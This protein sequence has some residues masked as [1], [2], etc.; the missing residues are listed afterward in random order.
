MLGSEVFDLKWNKKNGTEQRMLIRSRVLYLATT[1]C[2]SAATGIRIT[3]TGVNAATTGIDDIT[4]GIA[5]ATAFFSTFF[6]VFIFTHKDHLLELNKRST[7]PF[8]A[9]A[10]IFP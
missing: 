4:T 6:Y 2:Y 7:L 10:S 3:S 8:E 1:R 5:L 9:R